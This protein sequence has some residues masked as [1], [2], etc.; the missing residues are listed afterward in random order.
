MARP[1]GGLWRARAAE[2]IH[3]IGRLTLSVFQS[4]AWVSVVFL[5]MCTSYSP[6]EFLMRLKIPLPPNFS[7]RLLLS[8]ASF[9]NNSFNRL[10]RQPSWRQE[11]TG[12][13]LPGFGREPRQP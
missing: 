6:T 11:S 3:E 10:R 2:G 12:V 9:L 13:E 8:T 1:S 4:G 7:L 5:S